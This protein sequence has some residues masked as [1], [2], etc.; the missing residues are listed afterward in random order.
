MYACCRALPRLLPRPFA[1]VGGG[2]RLLTCTPNTLPVSSTHEG[3]HSP[4]LNGAKPSVETVEKWLQEKREALFDELQTL[5]A[6]GQAVFTNSEL[7]LKRIDVY[8]FDFDYTLVHYTHE[9]HRLIY[10]LV[11]D[12]L[13]HKLNYPA[14]IMSLSFDPSFAIRG[15]HCD[16]RNGFLMKIDAYNHIQ[17]SSVF[18]GHSPVSADTVLEHYR[19]THVP[20]HV[21]DQLPTSSHWRLTQ[22]LDLFSIPDC[23]LYANIIEYFISKSISFDPHLLF[24][25]VQN[26]VM[27]VHHSGT[28]HSEIAKDLERYTHRRPRLPELLNRLKAAGKKLFLITN[29]PYWFVNKG[30]CHVVQSVDWRDLFDVIVVDA[31]KPTFYTDDQRPFRSLNGDSMTP[32]WNRVESLETGRVYSQGNV[33]SFTEMTGWSGAGVL[34]FGDH[35]FSDLADPILQH[36]WKTGAIIPELE[37]EIS[38]ANSAKFKRKLADVLALEKLLLRKQDFYDDPA[39]VERME[40]YKLERNNAR[41][42]LKD[43][44]NPRF[45]SVFRTEK[46]PTYF[47]RRLAT[48]SN[49]YMSS[50]ENLMDYSLDYTFFPRRAALP[51]EPDLNFDS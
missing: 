14:D 6:N 42:F 32:T 47:N 37:K 33:N 45:G 22:F 29:S 39:L 8:G 49:L 12:R 7:S 24:E 20:M 10:N 18:R 34:Y 21:T 46:S 38:T 35:V 11:R 28:I 30:M 48:F 26:T 25:D 19:G 2:R 9:V 15:L 31:R 17:L 40:E 16:M 27:E 4:L 5:N 1:A 50:L 3:T 23:T 44:H 13:V 41:T 36:G 51:H 43:A